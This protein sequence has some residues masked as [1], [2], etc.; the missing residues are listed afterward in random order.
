[1]IDMK[2]TQGVEYAERV[3]VINK[4]TDTLTDKPQNIDLQQNKNQ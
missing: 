3:S 1:M 2:N 4:N